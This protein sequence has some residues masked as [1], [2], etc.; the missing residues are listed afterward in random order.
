MGRRISWSLVTAL[1]LPLL[2]MALPAKRAEAQ[3]T[4]LPAVA[5]LEF[6]VLPSIKASGIL[7]RNATDA[8]V[9]EMQR[10]GRFDVTP[11]T[12]L[13]Q[14]LQ[15]LGLTPPLDNNGVVRL[16]QALGVDFVLTGDVTNV[17]FTEN[18]RR[19]R[20]TVSA[21]LID[22]T[23]GE[24]ANGAIETGY[25]NPPAPGFQPDDEALINQALTN[26]AFNA[27]RTINNYTLPEATVLLTRS[28]E[29]TLNRGVRDGL[30]PGQEMIV[31]RGNE[32]V[33]RL[34]VVTVNPTDSI[35][36]ITDPGKGI[37]PEDRARAIFQIPGIAKADDGTY[38]RSPIGDTES[39]KPAR[40]KN[41]KSIVAVIIG[42]ALAV[43]LASLLFNKKSNT[44]NAGIS[45]VTARAFAEGS[46]GIAGDPSAAR[47]LVSWQASRDIPANNVIEYH[48]FRDGAIIA[49]VN[50]GN[51]EFIDSTNIPTIVNYQGI[52]FG[53]G[54]TTTTGTT[55]AGTTTV[56][57]TTGTTTT[58][59][60]GG[61][62]GTTGNT[63]TDPSQ[64]TALTAFSRAVSPLGVGQTHTYR[65][66]V[67]FTQVRVPVSSTTGGGTTGGGTTGG[68]TT[69]GGT[70]GGAAT[71]GGT[72]G[73]TAGTV[74]Y[75]ETPV[76]ATS[77]SATPITRPGATGPVSDQN[78][79]RV[80]VTYRT[81]QGAN[82]YIVEF[83]SDPSFNNKKTRG[84][85]FSAFTSGVDSQTAILDLS[86]DF[87]NLNSGDRIYYRVGA[88]NSNDS[89]GP[90]A[91]DTPNGGEY[92]Y[93]ADNVS[94]AKLG[95]PPNPP[96]LTP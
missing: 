41:S 71:G 87:S 82:Q 45:S 14:Q 13:N 44:A 65:V 69:G 48:V 53:N 67:L 6:T 94:F 64:P 19:A 25:S 80:R 20:I 76:L 8:V 37:R 29:V 30:Q 68:G 74:F 60:T 3:V 47:V 54:G 28:D 10:T 33:G 56:G 22:V 66:N 79:Q 16:G 31:V 18:P 12:Q 7:G 75:R 51:R 24:F 50:Q 85:F 72:A 26:A 81:V 9:L 88:R 52:D 17:A 1:L 96:Q 11:R 90:L 59:T 57:T 93:S 61:T 63:V 92:I 34:R 21:R 86:G 38:K 89:P 83:A 42:I 77:G 27:V 95:T 4:R 32:R 70:T 46:S 5:A 49:A 62:T 78:L 15:E 2:V 73:N 23:S 35:A 84:P 40:K 58:G 91:R 36:T 43:L 39:Y 55:T